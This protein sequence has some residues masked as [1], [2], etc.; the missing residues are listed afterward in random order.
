MY[1]LKQAA[2]LAYNQLVQHLHPYGY[3]PIPNSPGL[4]KHKS[5]KT[6]FSLCVDDF[7]IKYFSPQDAKHL[8]NALK[9][10]YEI[11]VNYEG[12]KYCGLN[13]K[14]NYRINMQN[15]VTGVIT[16]DCVWMSAQKIKELIAFLEGI[17]GWFC[18]A[19]CNVIEGWK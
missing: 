2:I 12:G 13:I 8:L 3:F 14:W 16:N 11:S 10:A 18:L 17:F 9:K 19:V 4:W 15:H 5:R 7:G 1:G 6:C